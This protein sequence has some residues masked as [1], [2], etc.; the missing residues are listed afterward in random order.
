MTS[1]S[2]IVTTQRPQFQRPGT[3]AHGPHP[4]RRQVGVEMSYTAGEA[5]AIFFVLS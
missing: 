1:Y 4:S 5:S 2:L 3:I